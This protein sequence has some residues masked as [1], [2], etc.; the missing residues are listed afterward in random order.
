[1]PFRSH[2]RLLAVLAILTLAACGAEP[3]GSASS[4]TPPRITLYTSVTQN[5]VDAV[6]AGFK[7]AHPGAEVEVFRAAT[8]ALNARVAGDQRSGGL[9]ADVMWGTDPLSMHAYADQKL[10]AA[11]PLPDLAGVPEEFRTDTFWGTRVLFV[12]V[13]ARKDLTPAPT[14]W[15]SLADPAYRGK[16]AVPDPA[17]AGSAFAA[18]GYFSQAP[19]F[20]MDYYRRLAANGAVQVATPPEVVTAV[21]QGRYRLGITLD[22]EVR[23][24]AAKGSPVTLAWPKEGAIAVYSPIAA[25]ATSKQPDAARTFLAY[26]LSEDGQ[27]RIAKTGWQPVLAQIPG[28]ERPAGATSVSPDWPALYGKQR[29]LLREYQSIFGG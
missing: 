14:G 9:R 17:T 1:M 11:W 2:P 22:T 13:V 5:T 28:P 7:E 25:T 12:V 18:L 16:V 4:T 26:V 29:D 21:A 3:A 10:L 27:R 15:A 6:V 19:G 20:G 24:A 8:G 23:A